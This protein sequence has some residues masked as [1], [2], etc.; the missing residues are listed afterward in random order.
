MVHHPSH[1]AEMR[2]ERSSQ[3]ACCGARSSEPR[4]EVL[5]RCTVCSHHWADTRLSTEE[6]AALYDDS[7]FQGEEYFDY[8]LEESALRK[9]FRKRLADIARH[10]PE[11]ASLWEVGTAY[12]YFLSEAERRFRKVAG[13]DIS[14]FAT[15]QAR[16]RF[17]LDVR[18]GDYLSLE[19]GE[20][21]DVIC[22]WDVVE[23]LQQPQLTLQKAHRDLRDRGLLVLS[24][25]D[26]GSLAA[27]MRGRHWRLIHPPTHLHYFTRE[28][29]Q[30]LLQGIGFGDLQICYHA[31]WRSADAVSYRLS[32]SSG[33]TLSRA[34]RVLK[35]RGLLSF[36]FPF[37]T[38]D[39]MTVYATKLS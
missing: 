19:L 37:N 35:R 27:R 18:A 4:L 14:E 13:C 6:V 10:R 33:P 20:E 28:S 15:K 38:F 23:H 16:E 8:A 36:S 21:V 34:Y 29:I 22:L 32:R 12:G 7:Y 31:F 30:R 26:I 5:L 3:C 17:G 25:G 24:T 1:P 2:E 39:I 9:N 11:A